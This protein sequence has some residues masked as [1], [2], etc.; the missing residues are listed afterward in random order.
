MPAHTGSRTA[1]PDRRRRPALAAERGLV[2]GAQHMDEEALTSLFNTYYPKVYGYAYVHLGNVHA[3]EDLASEVMLQILESIPKY[4]FTGAPF[5]AWVFRIARNRLIDSRRRARSARE[6]ALNENAAL[7]GPTT[8]ALAEN[9]L[10]RGALYQALQRLTKR[11]A[12]V[13]VLRF[14]EDMDVRT[15][16]GT[17]G[18]GT[19]AVKTV[20]HRALR[21]LR[22]ILSPDG[23]VAAGRIAALAGET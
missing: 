12:E 21:S 10:Q 17:L 2:S 22:R 1:C 20:Q 13:I 9:A 3:A 6:V 18:C 8:E 4:R 19:G 23:E 7:S 16:A 5:A 14:L 11:Q 15:V